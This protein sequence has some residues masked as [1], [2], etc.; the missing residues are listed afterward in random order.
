M[1]L[2]FPM[3]RCQVLW[4]KTC[5]Q[6]S[7]SQILF[8]NPKNYSLGDV[9]RFC[10]NPWCDST[11]IFDQISN[12]SNVYLSSGR[13]WTATSLVIYYHFPSVSKSR[14]PPQNFWS[15][16]SFIPI[17]LFAPILVFLWQIDRLWSHTLWKLSVHFRHQ[18]HKEN[19]LYKTSH[20]SY[21]VED[22]KWNSVCGRM[23]V[24]ST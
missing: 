3:L 22:K 8:Q 6:F 12:S 24:D 18:W 14:I 16:D 23:L 10:Y 17:S 1:W 4:D 19:W 13:F 2:I 15:V 7:L 21:P 11:V 5:A 20:N 9:Q